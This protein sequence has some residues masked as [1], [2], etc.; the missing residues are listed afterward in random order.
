MITHLSTA[1]N[2]GTHLSRVGY[3]QHIMQMKN[4]SVQEARKIK[5]EL[6]SYQS[7]I[8]ASV[9]AESLLQVKV[10]RYPV[11]NNQ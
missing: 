6:S 9:F 3:L 2:V 8:W 11:S 1:D 10:Y 4:A 5:N 7:L